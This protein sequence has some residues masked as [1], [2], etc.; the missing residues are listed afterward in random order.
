[1][2]ACLRASGVSSVS[3]FD[4]WIHKRSIERAPRVAT[5]QSIACVS[6]VWG[7]AGARP[8]HWLRGQLTATKQ[9][10]NKTIIS[11]IIIIIVIIVI[12]I[13][14]IIIILDMIIIIVSI[15]F[16]II[17]VIIRGSSRYAT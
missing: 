9:K 3:L 12:I 11:I 13:L 17:I 4:V 8:S 7:P 5:L 2:T 1:M 15:T 10:Q 14:I 6:R 16:I